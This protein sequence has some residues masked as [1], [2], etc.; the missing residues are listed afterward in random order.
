MT[1]SLLC[2][3][4]VFAR[5]VLILAESVQNDWCTWS[6][7]TALEIFASEPETSY[8][9][10]LR[11]PGSNKT[12]HW[13]NWASDLS[14]IARVGSG[15]IVRLQAFTTANNWWVAEGA[16]YGVP[17]AL[18]NI[19]SSACL[20]DSSGGKFPCGRIGPHLLTGPIFVDGAEVGDVLQVDIL[21][22][23]PFLDWGWNRVAPDVGSI[24]GFEGGWDI[25][26]L[27]LRRR[28]VELPWGGELPWNATGTGPFFG[29]IGTAP[30]PEMGNVSS[31]APWEQFGGNIDNKH[32]AA[33]STVY[34]P[35]N[36][37][38]A[39]FSAGDGHAVQGDGEVCV[40]ALE[41]SLV[42]DF[43]LTVRRDLGSRGPLGGRGSR[44]VR[45]VPEGATRPPQVGGC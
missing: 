11:V 3:L 15:Q 29:S 22:A 20:G 45:W 6:K 40:T 18:K 42:G 38:G 28:T 14:P 32:L 37:R 19:Y 7:P 36:V 31:V 10:D 9:I 2:F 41:A 44:G 5:D 25:F 26:G 24:K 39:L 30:P 16:G 17:E 21:R 33:G 23:E 1:P 13:G 12:T 34:L 8:H 35:V 4:F 27:D 43:R